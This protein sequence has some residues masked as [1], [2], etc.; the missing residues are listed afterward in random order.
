MIEAKIRQYEECDRAQCRRLWRELTEWHR[1][2]Y[3]EPTIGGE[4]PEDAFDEH[5]AKVGPNNLWVA[6]HE[7]RIIGLVGMIAEE[8]EA[9]VEPVIVSAAYRGRGIGQQLIT[10]IIAVAQK[11][12]YRFLNVKPVAR[13]EAAIRFFYNQGFHTLGHVQLFIDFSGGS[14]RPGLELFGYDFSY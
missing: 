5:L 1:E 6:V 10:T 11:R 14:W 8:K 13:N 7:S 4:T 9:E 3:R 2:I 12:G